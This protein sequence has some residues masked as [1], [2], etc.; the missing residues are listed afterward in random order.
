MYPSFFQ[1]LILNDWFCA[2]CELQVAKIAMR[3]DFLL[4]NPISRKVHMTAHFG[5]D[6]H[7]DR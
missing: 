7:M 2:V 6:L 1:Y 5:R 4:T 3:F